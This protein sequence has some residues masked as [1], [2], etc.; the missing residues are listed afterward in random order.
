MLYRLDFVDKDGWYENDIIAA[1]FFTS[2]EK[3]LE[4]ASAYLEVD[5]Y[6][7]EMCETRVYPIEVDPIF[8]KQEDEDCDW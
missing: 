3:A 5:G 7:R 1:G 4:Y 2:R 6:T 8:V